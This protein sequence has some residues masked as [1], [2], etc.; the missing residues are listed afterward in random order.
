MSFLQE[1]I[2]RKRLFKNICDG[3]TLDVSSGRKLLIVIKAD[4][5]QVKYKIW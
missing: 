1:W 3:T 5:Q 2:E 4:V